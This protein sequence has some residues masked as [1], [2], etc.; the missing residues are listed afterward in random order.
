MFGD[1]SAHFF[2]LLIAVVF[3]LF[4][5]MILGHIVVHQIIDDAY[6]KLYTNVA[7]ISMFIVSFLVGMIAWQGLGVIRILFWVIG[8]I[9]T[10]GNST[11]DAPTQAEMP[12]NSWKMM[13]YAVLTCGIYGFVIGYYNPELKLWLTVL[14]FSIVGGC[15]GVFLSALARFGLLPFIDK[16]QHY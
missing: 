9:L 15:W 4:G 12:P 1:S 6:T 7:A 3:I 8:Q 16:G 5:S 11:M 13:T 2:K 10:L 14:D